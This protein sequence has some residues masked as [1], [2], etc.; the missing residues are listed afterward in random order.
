[1]KKTGIHGDEVTLKAVKN[2]F[3]LKITII[4]TLREEG[5][6]AIPLVNNEVS[7]RLSMEHFFEVQGNHYLF[8]NLTSSKYQTSGNFNMEKAVS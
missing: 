2:H 1:M 8:S 5:V 3:N 6:T 4:L 7:T